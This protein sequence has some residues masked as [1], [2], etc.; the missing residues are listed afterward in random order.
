MPREIWKAK[1]RGAGGQRALCSGRQGK[2]RAPPDAGTAP[3]SARPPRARGW[4]PQPLPRCPPPLS[5]QEMSPGGPG[6]CFHT[7]LSALS[8]SLLFLFISL[9]I[10]TGNRIGLGLLAD[11][12]AIPPARSRSGRTRAAPRVSAQLGSAAPGERWKP[13]MPALVQE[14]AGLPQPCRARAGPAT[15]CRATAHPQPAPPRSALS[16]ARMPACPAGRTALLGAP[17]AAGRV[18]WAAG[19]GRAWAGGRHRA[20]GGVGPGAHRA[21][22]GSGTG[23]ES[24]AFGSAPPAAM[25]RIPAAVFVTLPHV[26]R[27]G[28]GG[29]FAAGPDL[30][31]CPGF[32]LPREGSFSLGLRNTGAAKPDAEAARRRSPEG[33]SGAEIPERR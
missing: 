21:R 19:P 4:Q 6:L 25:P 29:S 8:P 26:V 3:R 28:E 31:A 16:S 14:M 30:P 12:P 27:K 17:P 2:H 1:S 33:Q 22:T 32:L 10:L 7:L 5:V 20:P 13:P 18:R 11:H 24:S 15:Q 23:S 9:F